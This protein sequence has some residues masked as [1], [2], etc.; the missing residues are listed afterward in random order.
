MTIRIARSPASWVLAAALAAG[1]DSGRDSPSAPPPVYTNGAPSAAVGPVVVYGTVTA[2]GSVWVNGVRY[3]TSQATIKVDD[4][5]ATEGELHVGDVVRLLGHYAPG[6]GPSVATSVDVK[7]AL[8]GPVSSVDPAGTSLVVLGQT[9]LI[10][11]G[12]IFDASVPQQSLAGL[13]AGDIVEV[14]G[15]PSRGGRIV[16]SRIAMKPL[17][18]RGFKVTGTAANVD[19]DRLRFMVNGLVVDYGGV[20][21]TG[22]AYGGVANGERVEVLGSSLTEDG[23]L[24][25]TEIWP[26][27]PR[28]ALNASGMRMEL[29]GVIEAHDG[30]YGFFM[31]HGIR[32]TTSLAT[33]YWGPRLSSWIDAKAEVEGVVQPDSSVVASTVRFAHAA[34]IQLRARVDSVNPA[35]G[36]F[37]VLGV[38]V[39][40]R[41]FTRVTDESAIHAQPFDLSRLAPGDFVHIAGAEAVPGT[42]TVVASLVERTDAQDETQLQGYAGPAGTGLLYILGVAVRTTGTTRY[43]TPTGG[44][45]GALTFFF[46]LESSSLIDIRGAEVADDEIVANEA[47]YVDWPW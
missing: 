6:S 30:D 3:G 19:R 10:D 4:Q 41:P 15:L 38:T 14:S 47:R 26:G 39:E 8:H 45:I 9:V 40:T 5:M 35:A 11:A 23:E 32:V 28:G 44:D 12:V 43:P 33:R 7:H 36:T 13:A 24:V 2:L 20:P 37:V 22:L 46:D 31:L 1:C 21:R 17:G 18:P 34:P 16:A 25:A 27:D 29:E 42:R